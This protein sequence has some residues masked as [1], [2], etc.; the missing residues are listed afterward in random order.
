MNI[1]DSPGGT[2]WGLAIQAQDE[3]R[4]VELEGP[5]VRGISGIGAHIDR[6]T[7]EYWKDTLKVTPPDT[8]RE[9]AKLRSIP[10]D[11]RREFAQI[12][13]HIS[14]PDPGFQPDDWDVTQSYIDL[15]L[16]NDATLQTIAKVVAMLDILT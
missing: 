4:L 9:L 2:I 5:P 12:L 7:E 10:I 8:R 14:G 3:G 15:L 11:E 6:F 16:A 13:M 1:E